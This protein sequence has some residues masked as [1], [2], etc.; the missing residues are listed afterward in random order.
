M[1]RFEA[2]LVLEKVMM[3]LDDAKDSLADEVRDVLDGVWHNLSDDE[4]K[5]LDSRG[6]VSG[7]RFVGSGLTLDAEGIWLKK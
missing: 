2:Y 4:R 3:G 5:V 1:T 6:I 7:Q